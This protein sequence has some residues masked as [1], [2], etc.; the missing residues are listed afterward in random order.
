MQHMKLPRGV[1]AL[2]LCRLGVISQH[3]FHLGLKPM[4]SWNTFVYVCAHPAL[5]VLNASIYS[6]KTC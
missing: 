2:I 1:Y 6:G 3:V 4:V 5:P